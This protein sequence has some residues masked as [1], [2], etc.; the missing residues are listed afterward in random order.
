M[1]K[2]EM[3]LVDSAKSVLRQ[4]R[5]SENKIGDTVERDGL[6]DDGLLVGS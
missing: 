5:E 4:Q 1:V 3:G 2:L 6:V